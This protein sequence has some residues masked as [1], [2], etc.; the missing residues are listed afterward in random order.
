MFFH[1]NDETKEIKNN[2]LWKRNLLKKV[3]APSVEDR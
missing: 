3:E 1:K 2:K